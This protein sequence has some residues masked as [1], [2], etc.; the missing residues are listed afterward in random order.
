MC[1]ANECKDNARTHPSPVYFVRIIRHHII[2]PS[3]A[4]CPCVAPANLAAQAD[5][6]PFHLANLSPSLPLQGVSLGKSAGRPVEPACLSIAHEYEYSYKFLG[7]PRDPDL[8]TKISIVSLTCCVV[9]RRPASN[10]PYSVH[11][12]RSLDPPRVSSTRW[13][14]NSNAYLIL[15]P[16]D[17]SSSR[18]IPAQGRSPCSHPAPSP[19]LVRKY[20]EQTAVRQRSDSGPDIPGRYFKGCASADR[21]GC[22]GSPGG[23]ASASDLR[24]KRAAG[25]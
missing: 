14:C 13:R 20:A 15:P 21:A 24:R 17:A 16:A 11:T 12:Y 8:A 22:S 19:G 9:H 10:T 6:S 4:G 1:L 18:G 25:S 7:S 5:Y 3:R 23:R 2:H